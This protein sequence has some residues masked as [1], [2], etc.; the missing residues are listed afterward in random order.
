MRQPIEINVERELE[1]RRLLQS[2]PVVYSDLD[3]N[4]LPIK[5]EYITTPFR[6]R[7]ADLRRFSILYS[8]VLR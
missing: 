8:L 6:L 7:S 3:A 1:I 5:S 2:R 4:R